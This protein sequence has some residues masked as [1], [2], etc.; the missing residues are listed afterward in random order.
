MSAMEHSLAQ[1]HCGPSML[2]A[3]VFPALNLCENK[4][5]KQLQV[6]NRAPLGT[7]GAASHLPI[8]HHSKSNQSVN[9]QVLSYHGVGH[10]E[11]WAV[12]GYSH[13]ALF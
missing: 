3:V 4:P 7:C 8:C 9:A 13:H 10:L 12:K 1:C 6:F 5:D 11:I 2:S